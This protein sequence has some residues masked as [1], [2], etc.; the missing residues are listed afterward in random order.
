MPDHTVFVITD[1]CIPHVWKAIEDNIN[2]QLYLYCHA[3]SGPLPSQLATSNSTCV[4]VKI[5]EGNY[6]LATLETTLPTSLNNAL[7]TTA[8]SFTSFVVT[9]DELNQSS[10]ISMTRSSTYVRFNFLSDR[11]VSTTYSSITW[12]GENIDRNNL[13]SANDIFKFVKPAKVDTTMN[14]R[15]VKSDHINNVYLTSPIL[16]SFDTIATFNNNIIKT[17]LSMLVMVL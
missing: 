1:V 9:K 11:E 10:S 12:E 5:P 14:T 16:G 6:A 17:F 3:P 13:Q 4:I 2:D 8:R 7:N 15:F